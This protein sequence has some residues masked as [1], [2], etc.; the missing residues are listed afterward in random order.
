MHA[1]FSRDRLEA[2]LNKNS[3]TL[4][5]LCRGRHETLEQVRELIVDGP[6]GASQ[7]CPRQRQC[8]V[9]APL[10]PLA[11]PPERRLRR[12]LKEVTPER[13][14]TVLIRIPKS[15]QPPAVRWRVLERGSV[16]ALYRRRC[17]APQ[18]P[19][20]SQRPTLSLGPVPTQGDG[21]HGWGSARDGAR[22]GRRVARRGRNPKSSQ[23]SAQAAERGRTDTD[24]GKYGPVPSQRPIPNGG[25]KWRH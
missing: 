23:S 12:C 9:P 25:V 4:G 2:E 5:V 11:G 16:V 22:K 3:R 24:H 15:L 13:P 17:P 6:S 21:R 14:G 8:V 10:L 1:S 7:L 20:A 19:S 18:A